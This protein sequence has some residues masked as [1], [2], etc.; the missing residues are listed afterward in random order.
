MRHV[1]VQKFGTVEEEEACVEECR[2]FFDG[3]YHRNGNFDA[4]YRDM[5]VEDKLEIMESFVRVTPMPVKSCC[6]SVTVVTLTINMD[7]NIQGC[8]PCCGIQT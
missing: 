5:T 6:S 3:V 2:S 1:E 7:V 8:S 4:G